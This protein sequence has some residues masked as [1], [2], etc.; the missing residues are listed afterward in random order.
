MTV[1]ELVDRLT[2]L[3]NEQGLGNAEV[4]AKYGGLAGGVDVRELYGGV[5]VCTVLLPKYSEAFRLS[6][7]LDAAGV[8][9]HTEDVF[10]GLH[11][12]DDDAGWSV[13]EHALSYGAGDDLLEIGGSILTAAEREADDVLGHL[14]A[15]DVFGRICRVTGAARGGILPP[16][17]SF[18]IQVE[19]DSTP[20]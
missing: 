19:T 12:Y 9:F 16:R 13:I 2:L 7:M 17:K 5:R 20:V 1:R 10:G 4:M 15:E 3:C 18:W 8:A 11:L 14:T 6:R